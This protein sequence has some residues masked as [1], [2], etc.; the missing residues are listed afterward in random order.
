MESDP[1]LLEWHFV[2]DGFRGCFPFLEAPS[3]CLDELDG[4][5][6]DL[7]GAAVLAIVGRPLVLIEDSGDGDPSA[8]V[9]ILG[10]DL[11]QLVEGHA[12]DPAGFLFAGLEC[13]VE[14]GHGVSVW[15]VKDL[16]I[17]SQVPGHDA[18]VDH[19]WFSFLKMMG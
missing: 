16:G 9:E 11:G 13:D 6:D 17:V 3:V 8:F 1:L 15:R 5:P 14:R 10:A 12:L 19:G 2:I 18:L 7:E 4:V